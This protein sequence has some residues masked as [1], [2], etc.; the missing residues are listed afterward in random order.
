MSTFR[1]LIQHAVDITGSQQKLAESAGCS[2][3]H[4]SY[5]LTTAKRVSAETALSIERAT[6]GKVTRHEL[7]P[8]LF[9]QPEAQG[10]AA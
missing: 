5:L 4:I 2:Q 7:R 6:G 3:Q 1:D 10:D 8:D 9:P